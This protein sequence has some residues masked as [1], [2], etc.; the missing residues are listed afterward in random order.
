MKSTVKI[1]L[2]LFVFFQFA[3]S[4]LSFVAKDRGNEI[5]LVLFEEDEDEEDTSNETKE[6][7]EFKIEFL[8]ST[9]EL[10]FSKILF[11]KAA[12][13]FYYILGDYTSF[14][15]KIILPPELV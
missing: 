11:E 10:D 14:I 15:N 5:S 9:I 8:T 13:S 1:L 7:K 6:I 4:V 3:S 2:S 12:I